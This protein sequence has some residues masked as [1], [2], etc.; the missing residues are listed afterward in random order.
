MQTEYLTFIC[1]ILALCQT[2]TREKNSYKMSFG[3]QMDHRNGKNYLQCNLEDYGKIKEISNYY[4]NLSLRAI[5]SL[6]CTNHPVQIKLFTYKM[7]VCCQYQHTPA[8]W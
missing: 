8:D 2:D 6:S 7:R 4:L 1:G 3:N 5:L